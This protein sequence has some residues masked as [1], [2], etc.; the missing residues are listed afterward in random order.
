MSGTL[1]ALMRWANSRRDRPTGGDGTGRPWE[2][3]GVCGGG[4]IGCPRTLH[5]WWRDRGRNDG[6]NSARHRWLFIF[7]APL[8]AAAAAAVAAAKPAL[9]LAMVGLVAA[10]AAVAVWVAVADVRRD[11]GSAEVL[12]GVWQLLVLLQTLGMASI[13]E[14]RSKTR[15]VGF[16]PRAEAGVVGAVEPAAGLTWIWLQEVRALRRRGTA[17]TSSLRWRKVGGLWWGQAGRTRRG[18]DESRTGAIG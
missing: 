8:T 18:E 10:A 12:A 7:P 1:V 6:G 5:E 4:E 3:A 17:S 15:L 13:V 14:V 9:A 11:M 16:E 2:G